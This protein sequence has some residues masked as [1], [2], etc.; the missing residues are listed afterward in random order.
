MKL[1]PVFFLA[2]MAPHHICHSS[3]LSIMP[4][5]KPTADVHLSPLRRPSLSTPGFEGFTRQ[6]STSSDEGV[7]VDI[8]T[9][10]RAGRRLI[11]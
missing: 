1:F 2:D 8:A 3:S 6:D 7:V 11:A 9:I 10:Q 4:W 5:N